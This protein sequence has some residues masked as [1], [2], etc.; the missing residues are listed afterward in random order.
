M[1][2]IEIIAI[3]YGE[4]KYLIFLKI[5]SSNCKFNYNC[6]IEGSRHCMPLLLP[7][8]VFDP[9]RVQVLYS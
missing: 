3:F 8:L 7:I 1:A 2:N 9:S 6:Y 5:N 4:C